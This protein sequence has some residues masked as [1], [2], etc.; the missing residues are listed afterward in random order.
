MLSSR[1][2]DFTGIEQTLV[3]FC[4]KNAG[5]LEKFRKF[6]LINDQQQQQIKA[7]SLVL[8]VLFNDS[9]LEFLFKS[10]SL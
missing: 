4:R 8:C 10:Q 5:C 1:A 7:F 6:K 2:F 9:S 3:P